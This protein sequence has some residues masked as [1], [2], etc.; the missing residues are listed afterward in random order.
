MRGPRG[1]HAIRVA[2]HLSQ[3][4]HGVVSCRFAPHLARDSHHRRDVT[5]EE[6][7]VYMPLDVLL[8]R[9]QLDLRPLEVNCICVVP[10]HHL[11]THL[12]L[13]LDK[14]RVVLYARAVLQLNPMVHWLHVR[15]PHTLV[16]WFEVAFLCPPR[17]RPRS[18][19]LRSGVD[20]RGLGREKLLAE[21]RETFVDTKGAQ[22]HLGNSVRLVYRQR[23]DCRLL[24]RAEVNFLVP[25]GD[26]RRITGS[27]FF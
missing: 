20:G 5:D 6:R 16:L 18:I 23:L 17:F 13:E 4:R 1:L 12:L 9:R 11:R 26:V 22:V 25:R 14:W 3:K 8:G 15:L 21:I 19:V 7:V 27:L 10:A 24:K 2:R